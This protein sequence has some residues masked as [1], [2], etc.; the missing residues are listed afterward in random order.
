VAAPVGP[1]LGDP[2]RGREAAGA[3]AAAGV[4]SAAGV[5]EGGSCEPTM[6]ARMGAGSAAA[7]ASGRGGSVREAAPSAPAEG[8]RSAWLRA[9][10]LAGLDAC[11]TLRGVEG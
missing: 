11:S 8:E 7:A 10:R 2:A 6:T 3:G 1:A 5:E 4:G 9:V